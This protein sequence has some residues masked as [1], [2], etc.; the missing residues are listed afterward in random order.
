M[1]C[2]V[3]RRA[4]LEGLPE[5]PALP[6]QG[7]RLREYRESDLEAL[8]RLLKTA[9][10]DDNWTPEQTRK[11]LPNDPTVK[12]TFVVE[13]EGILI[14]TASV[15]L[16][17]DRFPGSGYIHWVGVDP[18]YRGRQLGQI[19]V[20]ATLYDFVLQGCR[21]AVLETEDFRLPA[22]RIYRK[23]GFTPVYLND[24]HRER[25]AKIDEAMGIGS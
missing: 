20:L 24:S 18:A 14:A 25:W 4:D 11:S 8:A 23:L 5:I 1:E 10:E 13:H 19:V 6:Q 16:L 9:F 17:P 22:I 12:K 7:C 21:D 15:R 3:M 2:I